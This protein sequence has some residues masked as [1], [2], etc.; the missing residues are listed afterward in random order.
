MLALLAGGISGC[1]ELGPLPQVEEV[2]ASVEP[3]IPVIV[4][5]QSGGYLLKLSLSVTNNA[6]ESLFFGTLCDLDWERENVGG[7]WA[8]IDPPHEC[9][10]ADKLLKRIDPG[11]SLPISFTRGGGSVL[12][13]PE[14]AR[15]GT[16]R[17]HLRL[18]RDQYGHN[19]LPDEYG[20]T[21]SD[22]IQSS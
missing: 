18:Y 21:T 22:T 16:Y 8:R 10:P 20:Y 14:F 19:P 9:P 15:P 13:R 7:G 4:R 5:T 2:S 1:A 11:M 3:V 12:N 17:L 6:R